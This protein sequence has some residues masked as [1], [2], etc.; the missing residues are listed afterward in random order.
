MSDLFTQLAVDKIVSLLDTVNADLKKKDKL[1]LVKCLVFGNYYIPVAVS[2]LYGEMYNIVTN[3]GEMPAG[4]PTN[5]RSKRLVIDELG[6]KSV[7]K[8]GESK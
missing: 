1:Q 5:W 7:L 3:T 2:N 8:K 4:M 6:L